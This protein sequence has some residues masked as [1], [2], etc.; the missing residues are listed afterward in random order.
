MPSVILKRVTGSGTDDEKR[1]DGIKLLGVTFNDKF[2]DG[3]IEEPIDVLDQTFSTAISADY[4]AFLVKGT[5]PSTNDPNEIELKYLGKNNK[6]TAV[7]FKYTE[8]GKMKKLLLLPN[9]DEG[10]Q[11]A[12]GDRISMQVNLPKDRTD[13]LDTH[14]YL[15]QVVSDIN[16]LASSSL[17]EQKQYVLGTIAFRRCL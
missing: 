12:A 9:T 2:R 8:N 4:K 10:M 6:E 11:N 14:E 1:M 3:L 16:T 15:G 17:E 7:R 5:L 13:L